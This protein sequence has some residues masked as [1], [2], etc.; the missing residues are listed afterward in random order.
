LRFDPAIQWGHVSANRLRVPPERRSAKST[1]SPR[2]VTCTCRLRFAAGLAAIH[3]FTAMQRA[4]LLDLD[5]PGERLCRSVHI[6]LQVTHRAPAS[7]AR[8]TGEGVH[9]HHRG[10]GPWRAMAKE[11]VL[12][13]QPLDGRDTRFK[14]RFIAQERRRRAMRWKEDLSCRSVADLE[15]PVMRDAHEIRETYQVV[16]EA[17]DLCSP[18]AAQW[19]GR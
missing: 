2:P 12:A 3:E 1:G 8:R 9:A 14:L 18:G 10:A 16:I 11:I 13:G 5:R 17:L 7:G 19:L 4:E 15:H 6:P